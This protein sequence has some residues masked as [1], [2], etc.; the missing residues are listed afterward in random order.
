M[1]HISCYRRN[2]DATSNRATHLARLSGYEYL[3]MFLGIK[4][5][6]QKFDIEVF[7]SDDA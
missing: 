2:D 1:S 7:F 4:L 3:E 5:N 6:G